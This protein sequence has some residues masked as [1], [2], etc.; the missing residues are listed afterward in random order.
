VTSVSDAPGTDPDAS[1]PRHRLRRRSKRLTRADRKE[2]RRQAGWS[3]L[4]IETRAPRSGRLEFDPPTLNL[5]DRHPEG[6]SMYRQ[7]K[8]YIE[9]GTVFAALVAMGTLALVGFLVYRGTRVHLTQTGIADGDVITT[10]EAAQLQVTIVFADPEAAAEATL[11]YDGD[12]VAAPG[13]LG[14]TMVWAPPAP[15]EEGEHELSLA[16]P[17]ALLDDAQFH[18]DFTVDGTAPGLDVPSA[19][20]P[21]AID[22]EAEVHGVVEA[23]AELTA[24][25]DPVRLGDDGS[26]TLH[27]DRPPAG[28]INLEA[29]DEAGNVTTASVVVPVTYPGLR[30]VHVTAAAWGNQQ[31][32][33]GILS[34]IDEHRIDTVQLD[35]KDDS[36]TVGFDTTVPRAAEIGAAVRHYD[37]DTAIATLDNRGVRVVGRIVTFRDPV[38]AG[39][40][41]AEGRG[42]QVIQTPRGDIY[43]ATGM[44]T[45]PA[46]AAVRQYN[47]DIALD[48]VSRGVDDILWSDTRLPTSDLDSIVV[49]GLAGTPSDAVT[50]F[51][52]EAH[53]EL[54]QRG[55]YQGVTVEGEAADRGDQVG[56]DVT[57]IARNA[58]YVAPESYP[59]YWGDG[60]YG[61][62]DPRHQPGDLV[63][64]V[65]TR[66]Q[67]VTA[68]TGTV[69]VPWL[70]DFTARGVDYGDAEVRA[71]I[72]A[73]RGLGVERFL[74]W[75]P[76]VRYSAG[77][78]DPGA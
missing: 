52:A 55:A 51:L 42:D 72:E 77:G 66:Y 15:P 68:G 46:S 76:A 36:G 78:I 47:L 10:Q 74:L 70:Q 16:V 11:S 6:P 22:A 2:A 41:W 53:S 12:V 29:V 69:L 26:F 35:L 27:F 63:R 1:G 54:R 24:D 75:S 38:L 5:E 21:V 59:G 3:T 13:V 57:R 56:Q 64:G 25:D 17:R 23:G 4:T 37:L 44:Y 30:G 40:A 32:R 7:R 50:G 34:M 49:P 65:L 33:G 58:D 73:A 31:L 19:V 39:A 28:P 8:R 67:E 60:R 61:V 9:A 48:A 71:Q 45:N 62:A 20:D 43:D 18:W 14:D